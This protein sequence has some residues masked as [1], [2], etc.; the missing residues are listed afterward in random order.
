MPKWGVQG[1]RRS[2]KWK[3]GGKRQHMFIFVAMNYGGATCRLCL[4][5]FWDS[6]LW[7]HRHASFRKSKGIVWQ[8]SN[9]HIS[10]PIITLKSHRSA[11]QGVH[12][13]SHEVPIVGR[14]SAVGR[15]Q[16]ED[17]RWKD[18]QL[19]QFQL[20]LL[21]MCCFLTENLIGCISDSQ[22]K[23]PHLVFLQTGSIW[24]LQSFK[25]AHTHTH[26][27]VSV[28]LPHIRTYITYP[29][30]KCTFDIHRRMALM[31]TAARVASAP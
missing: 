19:F 11:G 2:S 8:G 31:L 6:G 1:A 7:Q 5:A 26:T 23:P 15:S 20:K 3:K 27:H 12:V 13:W 24:P 17:R 10:W 29:R 28:T 14:N 4:V 18:L 21:A 30:W 9:I 16:S 25:C 22:Q